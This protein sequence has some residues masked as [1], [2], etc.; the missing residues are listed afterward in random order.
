MELDT[1]AY[2]CGVAVLGEFPEDGW[3]WDHSNK[4]TLREKITEINRTLSSDLYRGIERRPVLTTLNVEQKKEWSVALNRC[5]F[6][7]LTSFVN[8]NTGNTIFMYYRP[9]VAKAKKRKS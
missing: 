5:G 2:C 9:E 8:P 7:Q 3:D 6:R 4:N 1:L